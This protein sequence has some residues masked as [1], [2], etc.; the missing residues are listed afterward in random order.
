MKTRKRAKTTGL[1]K[2]KAFV[3]SEDEEDSVTQPISHGVSEVVLPWLSPDVARTSRSP[4]SPRSPKKKPFGPAMAIA[5]KRPEV[6]EPPQATPE[7]MVEAPPV[8]DAGD[9]LIPGPVSTPLRLGV[10]MN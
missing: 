8:I 2:F 10:S 6:I 7:P 4:W 9:I 3:E 1:A 5:G